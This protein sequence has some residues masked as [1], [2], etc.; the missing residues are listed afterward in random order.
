MNDAIADRVWV[1]D[2]GQG[3]VEVERLACEHRL[4]AEW[5]GLADCVWQ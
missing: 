1:V 3:V 4:A 2:E 5:A